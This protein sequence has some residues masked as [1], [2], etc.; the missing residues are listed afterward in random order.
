MVSRRDLLSTVA[1]GGVVGSPLGVLSGRARGATLPGTFRDHESTSGQRP[2]R[3]QRVEPD[4]DA[5]FH[6]PYLLATPERFR[7]GPVPL[8]VEG[9]NADEFLSRE[10]ELG[11]AMGQIRGLAS[12]G[13][14]LSEALGVPHLKP[15][16]PENPG[17]DPIED[18]HEISMIDRST[19]LLDGTDLDRVD[20]Q[21]LRMADHARETILTEA[22]AD[23]A[24]STLHEQFVMY[25]L[26]TE[27]VCAERMAALHPE[28][29]LAI[30]AAG[31]NGLALVPLEELGGRS[32]DYH[33]GIADLESIIGEP[34]DASAHDDVNLF[35][36]NGGADT[37]NRLMMDKEEAL[38]RNNW[39]DN[40]ALYDT[41]R[42]VYGPRPIEDHVPRCQVAFE[43]AGVS[44]Q[45][46]VVEGMPHDDS[47][48]MHEIR[49]FLERSIEGED[50]SE[51]GQQ[52]RLPFDRTIT[53][54]TADP[55]V[56]DE[57]Q[58]EVS[59][60]FP[61]PEGL[62]T[63]EWQLDDGRSTGGPS[64]RFTFE[65]AG[66]YDVALAME[67]A[68]GQ[69]G[70][71]GMSLLGDGPSFAAFQYAVEP[72]GPRH[73]AESMEVPVGESKTFGVEVT[74]VGSV[75]GE[76][77]LEFVVG[78]ETVSSRDV[79]LDPS[80]STTVTFEHTFEETG[81]VDVRIP[82]AYADTMTVQERA[83]AF[84]L[85]DAQLSTSEVG[86]GEPVTVTATM[87]NGGTGP[88]EL[89]VQLTANGKP[90]A[91]TSV[92]LEVDETGTVSF[93][94]AF[95]EPGEYSLAI[96]DESVGTVSVAS[97]GPSET[98]SVGNT[99]SG[100][101]GLGVLAGLA[102]IGSAIGYAL[103]RDD[104]VE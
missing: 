85:V 36:V 59:G 64:A 72:P 77:S 90:V 74:N 38:R 11:R 53:L 18:K 37:K 76:R 61:P 14:W 41:A 16:F 27:G 56:G 63:Y 43:K 67:T 33:V 58:F 97:G 52:F 7:A 9:N 13:A 94:H 32:L 25:G 66:D 10:E 6:H 12:H 104:P 30:A 29:I 45:F 65:E 1:V 91:E 80:G 100:Q 15:L 73:L 57:L 24:D 98:E 46:R 87:R 89:P 39:K 48:A 82:P 47:M 71:L 3:V 75:S 86:A 83:P 28:E 54:G 68:H 34:Y 8:L 101:P 81:E 35:L 49:E 20:L 21:L 17:E 31:L 26:S 42:I 50:V 70:Q 19:M 44:A 55:G 62:V 78:G 92:G 88:G 103:Y 5:G 69:T 2:E 60:Q 40:E 93:E 96:N 95:D 99:S 84:E 4:P 22:L 102:G 23:V 79:Q 51:F